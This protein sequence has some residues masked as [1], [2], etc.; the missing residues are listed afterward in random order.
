MLEALSAK[1]DRYHAIQRELSSGELSPADVARLSREAGSLA[2]VA[3]RLTQRREHTSTLAGLETAAS[4]PHEDPEIVK[5]CLEDM[6]GV[7][8]RLEALDSALVLDLL[9]EDPTDHA[10]SVVLEVRGAVGG[11]EGCAFA[12]ELWC[13]YQGFA[14]T[15]GWR[16]QELS[17][18]DSAGGFCKHAT[19]V[20]AG[21][22]VYQVRC[23]PPPS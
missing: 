9:P 14:R 8:R 23:P 17:W 5:M 21:D 18:S 20:V 11:E 13:M 7:R 10:A 16:F 6:E 3:E 2:Q 4:T 12:G 22:D 1:R 19:A 15:K